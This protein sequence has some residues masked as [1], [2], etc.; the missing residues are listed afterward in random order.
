MARREA[1]AT[2][3]G[4]RALVVDVIRSAGSISRVELAD[5]TG[6]AQPSISNIVRDLLSD[7]IIRETGSASSV[8]GKPRT[9]ISINP[10]SRVGIGFH[11]GS[12]AMTC[13][14]IDLT[15]GVI[16]REVVPRTPGDGTLAEQVI[17][18]FD[19]FVDGLDLPKDKIEG[20]AVV[21]PTAYPGRDESVPAGVA[22]RLRERLGMPVIVENDAAAAALGEFWS[23]RVSRDQAF[24]SIYLAA[25]IG[26][27]FVFDGALVRGASADAGELGHTS[28]QYDGRPCPCGNRGCV[29]RY[30]SMT[31]TV[32][33]ARA[34]ADLRTRLAL[35]ASTS[36]SRGYDLV[37]R[38]AV[39]GDPAAF[40]ILDQSAGYLAV[41]ATS[42]VNLLD[43]R[44]LVLTG[45]G[46][47]VAGSIYAKRI[48]AHLERTAHAR[49]RHGIE[50][51]LSAQPRDAA[52]IGAAALVIQA[53]VAPGHSPSRNLN[54]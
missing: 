42:M 47:A 48:R 17:E 8:R 7:G 2:G 5:I 6:L 41:A 35:D 28:I 50:V 18:R 11:L 33:A 40:Q 23:R 4:S 19:S 24:G 46:V 44:R 3:P 52:S 12:D 22:L 9:L 36:T 54:D 10:A 1:P 16:G 21:A 14:A 31:A 25:G 49:T 13:V 26:A 53:A 43:L 27:G 38:A 20:L 29:E 32:D 51:E 45:P 30:A 39:S 15:G 34:N 37:A